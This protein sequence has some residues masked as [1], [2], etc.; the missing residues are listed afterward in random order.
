V[1]IT[2]ARRPGGGHLL[3]AE[4][5]LPGAPAEV[6]PFF[7]DAG[8][9]ERITPPWLRF[10]IV[11]PQPIEMRPGALID[12]R[13]RLRGVPIRW[14]TEITVWEPPDR[15]VDEQV[16][17]PYRWWSHEHRF[18]EADDGGTLATDA[19]DYGLRGGALVNRLLVQRELERIFAFRAAT[20]ARLFAGPAG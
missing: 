12:Y 3:Q 14:R 19:V 7:A 9:L 18:V 16:R 1:T 8:N 5:R 20:L 10:R 17:G 2:V 11:T 6:F 4:Q 15:F 13:L